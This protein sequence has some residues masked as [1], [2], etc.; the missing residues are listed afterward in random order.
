MYAILTICCTLYTT[1]CKGG[2]GSPSIQLSGSNG[3][4]LGR[5]H[6]GL[7]HSN[8][9]TDMANHALHHPSAHHSL[10]DQSQ[11]TDPPYDPHHQPMSEAIICPHCQMQLVLGRPSQLVACPRCLQIFDP[12][13]HRN[14]VCIGCSAQLAYPANAQY[15]QCPKC[16]T[17]MK[18][19]DINASH[20]NLHHHTEHH[21]NSIQPNMPSPGSNTANNSASQ[22]QQYSHPSPQS[23]VS[24]PHVSHNIHNNINNNHIIQ[25]TSIIQPHA[26]QQQNRSPNA[27][28]KR[29]D[30][31]APKAV[32][33]AYMYV[34]YT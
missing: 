15:I 26:L 3:I 33:N 19:P 34:N 28:K 23:I 16:N 18:S 32:V 21:Q 4:G 6:Y 12:H 31:N 14:A 20:D 13:A 2:S 22:Q 29:K 9:L 8:S 25:S 10:V 30:H 24:Q 7:Q 27:N 1:I 17:T 11:H 5:G